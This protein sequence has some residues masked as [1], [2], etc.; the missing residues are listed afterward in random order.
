[1]FDSFHEV[2][3][4]MGL[5]N[6]LCLEIMAVIC[7]SHCSLLYVGCVCVYTF[8]WGSVHVHAW[9]QRL[10]FCVIV[11]SIHHSYW[12]RVSPWTRSLRLAYTGWPLNS[13]DPLI[14]ASPV[15]RL[16]GTPWCPAM[17]MWGCQTH[18]LS[19][20]L[21]SHN[22]QMRSSVVNVISM[23]YM[24]IQEPESSKLLGYGTSGLRDLLLWNVWCQHFRSWS[25]RMAS[26]RLA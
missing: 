4:G 26:L 15:L 24:M 6:K 13:R 21:Y 22:S 18:M 12:N 2:E 25:R 20:M 9:R 11:H 23:I 10:I 14:S 5:R 8:V 17:W 7:R 3:R 1:M 16:P 19:Q